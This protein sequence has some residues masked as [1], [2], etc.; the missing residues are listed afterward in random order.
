MI[1]DQLISPLFLQKLP[2][3]QNFLLLYDINVLVSPTFFH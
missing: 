3:Y 2:L 1:I